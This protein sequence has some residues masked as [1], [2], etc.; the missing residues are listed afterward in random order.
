MKRHE[1]ATGTTMQESSHVDAGSSR[2]QW[3]RRLGAGASLSIASVSGCSAPDDAPSE[4]PSAE[5]PTST[6]EGVAPARTT[7]DDAHDRLSDVRG[8]VYFPARTFNHYQSWDQYNPGET[9]RDLSYASAVGLNA[10]RVLVSYEYWR[11]APAAHER[12]LDHFF[13]TARKQG[14]AVLPVLFESIGEPPT[15]SNLRERDVLRNGATRSPAHSVLRDE[16]AWDRP[17][18]FVRRVVDR[19]GDHDAL[20]AVEMMNEPGTWSPRV[21][22]T[23]AML[24]AA[25]AV[26]DG[27]PLT[28]GCKTLENNRQYGDAGVPLDVYQFHYNLP[29]T[30]AMMRAALEE[31]AGVSESVGAPVWLTEWQ[32]TR[33]EPPDLLVPN[34]SS[35]ASVVRESDVDGDFF[36]Q[37][38]LKPAYGYVQRLRGRL[39][40]L[41]HEDGRVYSLSDVHAISQTNGYWLEERGWPE[42]ASELRDRSRNATEG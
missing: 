8:A 33:T 13:E 32:R 14:V 34:Y 31:A 20:L 25:R 35:L 5:T 36:W 4:T 22:F 23:T 3:L 37:L 9:I 10:L 26:D 42:W 27:V 15:P 2:R 19:Y 21:A 18:R 16:A 12:K 41:F 38:M 1:Q 11:D 7:P 24:R 29:P 28:V 40:G 6:V 17:R 39:N 30:A